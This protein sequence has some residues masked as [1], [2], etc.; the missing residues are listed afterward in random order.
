MFEA[1]TDHYLGQRCI[2]SPRV[3]QSFAGVFKGSKAWQ[4]KDLQS[5][6]HRSAPAFRALPVE[7]EVE[8]ADVVLQ[9]RRELGQASGGT[10]HHPVTPAADAHGGTDAEHQVTQQL[11]Q[12]QEEQAEQGSRASRH[13]LDSGGSEREDGISWLEEHL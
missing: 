3:L 7:G 8:E 10:V 9:T 1:Q 4:K 12:Q 5:G 11:P 6:D 2:F 13:G